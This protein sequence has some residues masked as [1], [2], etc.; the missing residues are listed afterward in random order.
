MNQTRRSRTPARR[1]TGGPTSAT[2][3]RHTNRVGWSTTN[4]ATAFARGSTAAARSTA[5]GVA[6]A[7]ACPARR[8]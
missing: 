7:V 3:N 2:F 1:R 5:A 4:P 6:N 8:A